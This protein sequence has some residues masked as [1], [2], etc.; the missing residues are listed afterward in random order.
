MSPTRLPRAAS[1]MA[2]FTDTVDLPTPPLP[3]EMATTLSIPG[4]AIGVG[5]GT[6]AC[7]AVVVE[8]RYDMLLTHKHAPGGFLADH[9]ARIQ[10]RTP[11]VPIVFCDTRKAAE[12][13]AFRLLAAAAVEH[14]LVEADR[15]PA[16]A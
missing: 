7:A 16:P 8:G 3:D 12:E 2:T 10:A 9:L 13:Y 1:A 5:A 15:T 4:T 14:G 11:N 6:A